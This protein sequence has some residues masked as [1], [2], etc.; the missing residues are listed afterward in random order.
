[1]SVFSSLR[2]GAKEFLGGLFRITFSG[3][4]WIPFH[5]VRR[6]VTK[7]LYKSVGKG[8]SISRNVDVRTPRHIVIGSHT[9]INKH[10]LLDGRGGELV[11]GDNVDVAQE[12]QLWT[13]QHDYNSPDYKAVGRPVHIGDYA[14]IGTG[15]NI[16]RRPRRRGGGGGCRRSCDT[17]CRGL[18]GGRWCAGP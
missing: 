4:M 11:I 1:M 5:A 14:W 7:P 18:C 12:A 8:T 9:N 15:H 2:Q 17:R 3:V 13:L 16:A 10:V 6:V